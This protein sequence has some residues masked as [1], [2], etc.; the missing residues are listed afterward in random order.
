METVLFCS[1]VSTSGVFKN[2]CKSVKLEE[3]TGRLSK[4]ITDE[5]I[6]RVRDM[7][8]QNRQI[9]IDEVA[10]QPQISHCAACLVIHHKLAFYE[11]RS[12]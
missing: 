7:I 3:G 9:T 5:N 10:H 12:R 1:G 11:V 8:L 2:G 6:K 4:S